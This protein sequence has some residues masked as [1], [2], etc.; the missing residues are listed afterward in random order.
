MVSNVVSFIVRG[1]SDFKLILPEDASESLKFAADQFISHIEQVTG[2]QIPKIEGDTDLPSH[3]ILMGDH[4]QIR[5]RHP[6]IDFT[7]LGE[8]G[9]W[10]KFQ[11]GEIIIAGSP[12]RGALYGVISFLEQFLG[13]QWLSPEF[14][15]VPKLADVTLPVL[16]HFETPSFAY[17]IVTYLNL[18]DPDYSTFLKVNM[19]PFAEVYHGGAAGKLSTARMTHTFY[20]LVNPKL[21]FDDHPEYFS[22]VEGNRIRNL[23]QLCLS[24][25]EVIDIATKNVLKWFEEEPDIMSMGIVQNDCAGWCECPECQG[26]EERYGG[27]HI[28]PILLL[29]NHIGKALAKVHPEKY[30]HTIA[31][32]YSLKPPHGI[33]VR[34][35]VLVVACD[36]FPDSCDNKPIGQHPRT[37]RYLEIVKEWATITENLLVWH[38]CVDFVHFLLPFP[39]FRALY[40]DTKI[41]Q[42]IG[43]K[44][45]LFQATTQPG[46]YGEFEEFRN[47]FCNKIL[48]D[49]SL[50][51][52]EL[53]STFFN[54]F[55][56]PASPL[57]RQYFD[58]LQALA[59]DPRT[60]IHLYSGL[61]EIPALTRDF[62][63]HYQA[64]LKEALSLVENDPSRTR[65]VE[66]VLLSLDYAYLIFPV[67]F[68][69]V[70]GKIYPKDLKQRKEVY[71][72]FKEALKKFQIGVVGESIPVSAFIARQDLICQENNLLALAELAPTVMAI[73]E[74]LL[75]LVKEK[76]REDGYF[77]VNDFIIAALRRGFHPLHLNNWM[78][79]KEIADW[80]PDTDIWT[81]KLDLAK[82]KALLSPE[83]CMVRKYQLPKALDGMIKGLPRQVEDFEKE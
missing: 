15:F 39:N 2:S 51:Y 23:G 41:Y 49:T 13:I 44:G 16:S 38:Y 61:K 64:L 66:K 4:H 22:L 18:L 34:D 1:G 60:S 10:W 3:V 74:S 65:H 70:L 24:N 8:E 5:E 30:V 7:N 78:N 12:T 59:N 9:F 81:R 71:G 32:T 14:T 26:L 46:V 82:L 54:A 50:E 43:V 17:R 68:E 72:R 62:V 75:G 52:D 77:R 57:V 83:F 35:N 28:A 19:N 29:C 73:L 79:E 55:Y 45:I 56:G 6:E 53:V 11:P 67:E 31:Y 58:A 42:K 20:Q 63:M 27:A 37:E 25:P 76:A 48:W 36:M 40:E 33:E 21:Y 80:I 47:W 69:A